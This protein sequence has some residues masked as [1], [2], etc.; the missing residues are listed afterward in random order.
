MANTVIGN[1]ITYYSDLPS[2]GAIDVS[3]GDADTKKTHVD[4][5]TMLL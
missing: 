5:A 2:S 3:Q 4:V 1:E